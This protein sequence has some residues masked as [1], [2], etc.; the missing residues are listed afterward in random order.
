MAVDPGK[1]YQIPS[2]VPGTSRRLGCVPSEKKR[3]PPQLLTL[4]TSPLKRVHQTTL[5]GIAFDD[6]LNFA[7][8]KRAIISKARRTMGFVTHL[9]RGMT[10]SAFKNLFAALVL[11][12]LEF[13]LSVC[14][15]HQKTLRDA[16]ET[17]QRRAVYTLHRRSQSC[18]TGKSPLLTS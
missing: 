10:P 1:A 4:G 18:P 13:C 9:I 7:K 17:V 16:L 3:L 14:S 2:L 5:L 11:P 15:P 8:H 6:R 12:R